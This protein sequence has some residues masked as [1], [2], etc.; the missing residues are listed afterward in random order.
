MAPIVLVFGPLFGY[1]SWKDGHWRP[2]ADE[3]LDAVA[4]SRTRLSWSPLGLMSGRPG[5]Y[6]TAANT[7]AGYRRRR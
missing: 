1:A 4:F 5:A 6:S 7:K 2:A 3:P